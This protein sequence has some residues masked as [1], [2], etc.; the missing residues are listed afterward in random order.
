[1]HEKKLDAA[2]V[3]YH[4]AFVPRRMEGQAKN[5]VEEI[6]P[7]YGLTALTQPG[8]VSL[9]DNTP[10]N[11][12]LSPRAYSTNEREARHLIVFNETCLPLKII[13]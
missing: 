8:A 5:D 3:K 9:Q 13:A 4:R 6:Q 2:R 11:D 10:F 1:M 12:P 7:G